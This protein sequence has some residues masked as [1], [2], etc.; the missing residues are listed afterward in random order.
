MSAPEGTTAPG[1]TA[2]TARAYEKLIG[3]IASEALAVRRRD[4]SVRISDRGGLL[5]IEIT[6]AVSGQ[7]MPVLQRVE[8][9]RES[10]AARA[11][12]LTGAGV[13]AVSIHITDIRFDSRRA[14]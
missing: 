10:V 7:G 12:A 5:A 4:G 2:I 6:S 1:R 14:T 8:R 11:T 3:A 9:T 13:S